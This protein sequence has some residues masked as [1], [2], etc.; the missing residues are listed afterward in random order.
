MRAA[1]LPSCGLLAVQGKWSA[2]VATDEFVHHLRWFS[3]KIHGHMLEMNKRYCLQ[4]GFTS[5]I[6]PKD[7]DAGESS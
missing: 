2:L 6:A 7:S 5:I 3:I 4:R 1:R